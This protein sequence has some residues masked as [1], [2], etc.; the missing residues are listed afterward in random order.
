MKE[1]YYWADKIAKK[2]IKRVKNSDILKKLV[3]NNKYGYLV[4]DEKTPSGVIHIG[5]GRGWIIHDVIAKALRDR[6]VKASFVL[7]SDDMDPLDKESKELTKEQNEKYMGVP[8]RYIP[9]P[10]KGYESYADYYFSQATEK[11]DEFGIK[12]ILESTGQEYEKGTF[13]K[14]IKIA[15]NNA[16][17][18]QDI[19]KK[20]YGDDVDAAKRLPFN[21]RCPKCGK[22]ATTLASKWDKKKEKIY[23]ECRDDVQ[24]W[25]KG[26]NT[27]A[28]ISPYNGNGK[29]PWKVEWPA[30]W[31]S[32]GV[33]VETAGKDHFTKGG[34][35][36]IGCMISMDVFNYPPPYPSKGYKTGPG[37]EWVTVGGKSMSTSRGRGYSFAESTELAPA[38]ILRYMQVKA[39]PNAVIDFQ[40][41]ESNDL[42]L[43]YERYDRTERIYFGKE[44]VDKKE[45]A[46]QRRIYELS[47]IGKIPKKLPP[48]IPFT[49]AAVLAQIFKSDKDVIE[50]L[51]ETDHLSDKLSTKEIEY[52]KERIDFARKWVKEF[53]SDRYKFSLQNKVSDDI[54]FSEKQVKALHLLSEKLKESKYNEKEL[55]NEFYRIC[56]KIDIKTKEFFQGAY[57]ALL[58]KKRGPKLAPFILAAKQKSIELFSEANVSKRKNKEE[59]MNMIEFDDWKKLELKVGRIIKAAKIKKADKLYKLIIDIGKK[60]PIQIVSSLVDYYSIKELINK[61][62]IVLVNLK[63]ARFKG[64]IS[65]GMI[66]CAENKDNCVLLS[67]DKDIKPGSPVT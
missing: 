38:S 64:E 66:L 23:F 22:I 26:C 45:Q 24:P 20:L 62:V 12:A 8:F 41:Y 18:I 67:V 19:Y 46:K 17:K 1:T 59:N 43:L 32:K 53:A 13:N 63:P 10:K 34:S 9:S 3:K 21:V 5:S 49:H 48:Q 52:V 42:I 33:I 65:E 15:L 7:S 29:F 28:W 16:H 40:P 36:T 54:V 11:F 31:L 14:T 37:Y 51:K 56:K 55:Y 2:V 30:K 4:Y 27:K 6:G 50:N 35:R 44:K 39:R 61:K 58:N 57:L 25:A 47:Q 60:E